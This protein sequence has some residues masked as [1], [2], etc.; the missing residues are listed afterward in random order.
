VPVPEAR[1]L[2]EL[3]GYLEHCSNEDRRRILS[4]HTETVG[5]AMLNEQ[6]HLLPLAA[7]LFDLAEV[8]FP[9]SR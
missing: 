2:D 5:A 3:N 7:E 6:P 8:S 1:S 9:N 4:G